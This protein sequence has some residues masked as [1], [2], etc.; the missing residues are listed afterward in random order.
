MKI[1]M[2]VNYYMFCNVILKNHFA[3]CV[4]LF[5]EVRRMSLVEENTDYSPDFV[6]LPSITFIPLRKRY[7]NETSQIQIF[8]RC[9]IQTQVINTR[10]V[11]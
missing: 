3:I 1:E 9:S 11:W 6:K 5:F 10:K 4:H 2:I 7:V 8:G